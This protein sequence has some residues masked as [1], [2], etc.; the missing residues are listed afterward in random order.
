MAADGAENENKNGGKQDA[1]VGAE[2]T[3]EEKEELPLDCDV[4][5]KTPD[6]EVSTIQ[7]CSFDNEYL[8]RMEAFCFESEW[9]T[10]NTVGLTSGCAA[11]CSIVL[12]LSA[13]DRTL[14]PSLS[15]LFPLIFPPLSRSVSSVV[16]Y[17]APMSGWATPAVSFGTT[18]EETAARTPNAGKRNNRRDLFSS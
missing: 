18:S 10:S 2:K 15:R 8:R 12:E 9:N 16:P 11:C 6:M 5:G 7:N 14:L 3:D 1:K 17:T 13:E 4:C